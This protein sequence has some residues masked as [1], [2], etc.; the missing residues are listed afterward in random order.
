MT[1]SA[2]T[3]RRAQDDEP[4]TDS[5]S[6]LLTEHFGFN[7][8]VFVDALVYAANEHLYSIG[9]QFEEFA[10][11]QLKASVKKAIKKEKEAKSDASKREKGSSTNS[12]LAKMTATQIDAAAERGVHGVLTLM[13]NALDH[14]FDSLELYCLKT[15]FGI[16]PSQAQAITLKHHR[17]LDLR[18]A[19]ERVAEGDALSAQEECM[20]LERRETEMQQKLE[21]ARKTR[22]ALRIANLVA[23]QNL[24]RTN[25][26]ADT[27][28]F[29]ID[30]SGVA[31]DTS[32]PQLAKKLRYDAQG[33]MDAL[34]HLSSTNPLGPSLINADR[35]GTMN[36]REK[37]AVIDASGAS[38]KDKSAW[39]RGREA[40][41]NWE[42]DRIIKLVQTRGNEN[43]DHTVASFFFASPSKDA[44]MYA[45]AGPKRRRTTYTSGVHDQTEAGD[46]T[47]IGEVEDVENLADIVSK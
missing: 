16:K 2:M 45:T 10:K 46:N 35:A 1:S 24:A 15:V 36:D 12:T 29:M 39:E 20:E 19:E 25:K 4:S 14:V 43:P 5:N 26:V 37:K 17:D 42:M 28:A 32:T 7:P 23:D 30:D 11:K 9:G 41:I 34:D 21:K 31:L 27:F 38:E 22:H 13:E 44:S 33:L 18:T 8:R 47:R 40:Y 6:E 3:A